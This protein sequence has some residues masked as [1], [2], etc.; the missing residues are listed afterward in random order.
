MKETAKLI[1]RTQRISLDHLKK[2]NT[3]DYQGKRTPRDSRKSRQ[4][5]KEVRNVAQLRKRH[6]E[7][8]HR[9]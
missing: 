6:Q 5:H 2:E 4:G 8:R 3:Q 1:L 9:N 7:I